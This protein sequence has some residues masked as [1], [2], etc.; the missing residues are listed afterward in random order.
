MS[1]RGSEVNVPMDNL[2]DVVEMATNE[3]GNHNLIVILVMVLMAIV[4]IIDNWT[5]LKNYLGIKN[6]IELHEEEQGRQI[7]E[8]KDKIS[9]LETEVNDLK[10]YSKEAK[11]KRIEFENTTID[12]LKKI[13]A[14][15]LEE[16]IE[17]NRSEILDFASGLKIRNYNQESYTHIFDLYSKYEKL[18]KD[19]NLV[20]GYVE[21]S[22]EYIRKR[23]A[24]QLENN[25]SGVD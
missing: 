14:D 18:I 6:G 11:D 3:T 10:Q 24:Q 7:C 23:Y 1:Q 16:K 22:M 9:E 4:F 25:F 15:M 20:N 13:R 17:R 2:T 12:T 8:L 19:N 5:K 21:V